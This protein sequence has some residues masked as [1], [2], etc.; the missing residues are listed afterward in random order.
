M[1]R[2]ITA[3]AFRRAELNAVMGN[4]EADLRGAAI[5]GGSAIVEANAVMGGIEIIVPDN[6]R[7]VNESTSALGNIEDHTHPLP[8]GTEAPVLI[9]RGSAVMGTIEIRH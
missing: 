9:V 5:A 2:R 1:Q 4:I 8:P 3:P 7:I 6:W